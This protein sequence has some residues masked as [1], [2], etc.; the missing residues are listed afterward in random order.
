LSLF[1]AGL[2]AGGLWLSCSRDTVPR[3]SDP[4][5]AFETTGAEPSTGLR[6]PVD[7]TALPAASDKEEAVLGTGV[8]VCDR[9]LRMVCGCAQ[10][11]QSSALQRSCDLARLSLPEWKKSHNEEDEEL[12]VIKACQ[13]AFLYIQSTGQCDDVSY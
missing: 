2:L 3:D 7:P 12:A 9:Y 6:E 11:R 8:P 5:P 1:T 4:G 13:R 10:K